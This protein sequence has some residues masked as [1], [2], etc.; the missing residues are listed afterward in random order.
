[1]SKI[2]DR[3]AAAG[4]VLPQPNAPVAN[5]AKPNPLV[6]LAEA[7]GASLPHCGDEASPL[8]ARRS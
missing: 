3:L 4:I 5:Y 7:T 8:P 1:M 6:W 2:E